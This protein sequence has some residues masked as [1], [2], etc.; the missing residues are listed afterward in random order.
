MPQLSEEEYQDLQE[1]IKQ[2]SPEELRE[3][4]KQQCLFCQIIAGKISTR[5]I[6]EDETCLAILDINPANKGHLLLLPKEHYSILPLTPEKTVGHLFIVAKQLS[7][8]LLSV[9]K[10][11]ESDFGVSLFVANGAAAGQKAPH[12]IIH[13]IP[14]FINDGISLSPITREIDEEVLSELRV[15][16]SNKL[17]QLMGIK[18]MVAKKEEAKDK[19]TN[20]NEISQLFKNGL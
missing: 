18:K 11:K 12:L 15:K 2:M 9:L 19:K 16:I 1:K 4:Q 10:E 6:Y 3:L 20:L 8:V 5:K 13:L 14:R 17:N 7:Q